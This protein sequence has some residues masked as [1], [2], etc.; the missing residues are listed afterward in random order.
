MFCYG[1]GFFGKIIKRAPLCTCIEGLVA[2]GPRDRALPRAE[3]PRVQGQLLTL[4]G[5][6]E[7]PLVV[8]IPNVAGTA[9]IAAEPEANVI[10][11]DAE[12]AEDAAR[13]ANRLHADKNP[14]V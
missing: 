7:H 4:A 5:T 6:D 2:K 10:V 3:T 9:V 1:L 12:H 8:G 13:R 11:F 14:L